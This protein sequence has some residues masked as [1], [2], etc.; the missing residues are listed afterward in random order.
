MQLNDIIKHLD[1]RSQ[2]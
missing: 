2:V 1:K